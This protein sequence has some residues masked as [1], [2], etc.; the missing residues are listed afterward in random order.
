VDLLERYHAQPGRTVEMLAEFRDDG[1]RTSYDVV[2]E[3]IADLPRDAR[4]LDLA[5]GDGYLLAALAARGYSR[6]A[7]IDRSPHEL[8]AARTRLSRDE[9]ALHAGDA[10]ALPFGA[11]AFDAVVCHMALMLMEQVGTV[12][13]EIAR[14]LRPGGVL[15]AVIN[16]HC[17]DPAFAAFSRA[18]AEV[19]REAGL[20]RLRVGAPELFTAEGLRARLAP[21]ASSL[22]LH[23]FVVARR[24]SPSAL[25]PCFAAMYDVFRL[26]PPAQ[27]ALEQRVCAAW[28][29]LGGEVT[30]AMGMRLVRVRTAGEALAP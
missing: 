19:T 3:A 11:G 21:Y 1:G 13:A 8:V 26:P 25:W 24:G 14:V 28:C 2:V 29:A 15:V 23:D 9:A 27:A 10:A 12:V 22:A 20:A 6:L 17:P 30:A 16:R 18:L 4:V 7:G 5:C